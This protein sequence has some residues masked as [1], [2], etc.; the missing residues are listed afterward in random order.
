ME[1]RSLVVAAI[2]LGVASLRGLVQPPSSRADALPPAPPLPMAIGQ[3]KGEALQVP[4]WLHEE[5]PASRILS[6]VYRNRGG[7]DVHIYFITSSKPQAFHRATICYPGQGWRIEGRRLVTLAHG[8]AT[9]EAMLLNQKG[10][11]IATLA[12]YES[13]GRVTPN[14]HIARLWL[15]LGGLS[16][17]N[18]GPGQFVRLSTPISPGP[19]G[20][21]N[22]L[23]LLAAFGSQ[24][25]SSYS[26]GAPTGASP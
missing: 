22:A 21:G 25:F 5:I 2:L 9:A 7:E 13:G 4:A 11:R 10:V 6:R 19:Q 16:R 14:V 18:A 23:S 24:V 17:H 8:R 12:W 15:R 20:D 3:W 26:H 1:A